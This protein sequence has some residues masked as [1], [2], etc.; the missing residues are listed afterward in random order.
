MHYFAYLGYQKQPWFATARFQNEYNFHMH[1]QYVATQFYYF[2][3]LNQG[4]YYNVQFIAENTC[5]NGMC[6]HL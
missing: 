6:K 4:N 2:S 3:R 1:K 5:V